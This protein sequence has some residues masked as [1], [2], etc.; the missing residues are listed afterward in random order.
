MAEIP[1]TQGK[2]TLVNDEDFGWLSKYKWNAAHRNHTWYAARTNGA[3]GKRRL[4]L[5]HREILGLKPGD[6]KITDHINRNGLDNRRSNLRICTQAQNLTNRKI[7]NKHGLRGV[8]LTTGRNLKKPWE[9]R[10]KVKGEA[11]YLGRYETKF[12]AALAYDEAAIKYHGEF[13]DLNFGPA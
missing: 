4:I 8:R 12:R 13:A 3:A 2:L 9:A 10:I 6:G 7:V 1:L 11:I 5:M